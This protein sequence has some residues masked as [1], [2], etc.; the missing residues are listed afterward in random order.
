MKN[1]RSLLIEELNHTGD[2]RVFE[3]G[4]DAF[5][6]A[7]WSASTCSTSPALTKDEADTFMEDKFYHYK[8]KK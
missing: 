3:D 4:M 1:R 8:I 2:G 5:E 7:A 6:A